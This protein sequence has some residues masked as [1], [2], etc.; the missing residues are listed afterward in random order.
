VI[1]D[2]KQQI[3]LANKAFADRLGK[4]PSALQGVNPS[5]LGWSKPDGK[6]AEETLPWFEAINRG[7]TT[8]G[9]VL[10]TSGA[11]DQLRTLSVN[12][13]PIVGDRGER[14]GAIASF[15]DVTKLEQQ[16]IEIA[17]MLSAL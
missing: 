9:V 8:M 7:V 16:N 1:L 13:I 4:T 3:V 14:R 2:N 15:A 5:T 12:A 11:G 17:H 6:I 10:R